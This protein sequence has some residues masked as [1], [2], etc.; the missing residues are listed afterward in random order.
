MINFTK[1][2]D[3]ITTNGY[4][5]HLILDPDGDGGVLAEFQLWRRGWSICGDEYS[6]RVPVP[7]ITEAGQQAL[8]DT[9]EASLG[10]LLD[11]S[12]DYRAIEDTIYVWTLD[13]SDQEVYQVWDA[14]DYFEA[15]LY[16][17]VEGLRCGVAWD[18]LTDVTDD[19][20]QN[21]IVNDLDSYREYLEE[22][23]VYDL[24]TDDLRE[25]IER[26]R[27]EAMEAGDSAQVAL[28]DQA[29]DDD[30]AAIVDCVEAIYRTDAYTREYNW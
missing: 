17:L 27:K 8:Y 3:L 20:P 29:L 18:V 5:L 9:V 26:L 24:D 14:D 25:K 13:A 15:V 19:H 7:G 16:E 30:E 21:V 28:C 22:E 6:W 23:Y 2:E 10:E 1:N 4:E 12:L 11:G